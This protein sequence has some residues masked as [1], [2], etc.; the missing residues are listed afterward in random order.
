MVLDN[1]QD[2]FPQ[3]NIKYMINHKF[4]AN[5]NGHYIQ[6][7]HGKAPTFFLSLD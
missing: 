5:F 3:K 1:L 6:I 4:K 2:T 7:V